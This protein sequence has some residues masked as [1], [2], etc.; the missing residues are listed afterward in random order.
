MRIVVLALVL[1]FA[2]AARAFSCTV[3][4][5]GLAFGSYDWLSGSPLDSSGSVSWSCDVVSPVTIA[6]G[7]GSSSSFIPRRLQGGANGAD[8]NTYLDASC[9]TVWGDGTGG[10]STWAGSGTG[11]TIPI[12]GRVPAHQ[13]LV[14][15]SYNDSVV[16][17]VI[18]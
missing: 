12:F 2:P 4:S 1:V 7:R 6:L 16:V 15:G 5:T 9:T 14:A 13:A 10:T 11:G 18:F 8:Y 17:S 3:S